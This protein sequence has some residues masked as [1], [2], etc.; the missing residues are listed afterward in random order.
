M[1]VNRL[2]RSWQP[3]DGYDPL[4]LGWDLYCEAAMETAYSDGNNVTSIHD[5]SGN[6][7]DVAYQA[8]THGTWEEN[9]K[10]GQ[11][12]FSF[13]DNEA[14]YYTDHS[15]DVSQPYHLFI[16]LNADTD[17]A[18]RWAID[19]FTVGKQCAVWAFDPATWRLRAG[20]PM[21]TEGI[22]DGWHIFEFL[23]N[24]ASSSW[25]LDGASIWSGDAG[26]W[27]FS[28]VR[29]ACSASAATLGYQSFISLWGVHPGALTGD[30]LT[31]YRN[32]LSARYDIAV[33]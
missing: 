16:V 33:A 25:L 26:A 29:L 7:R 4:A 1:L 8:G 2:P 24:G 3:S 27:D 17:P 9:I 13:T 18:N 20:A 6:S 11:A 28:L 15:K 32:Y 12:A 30:D 23:I 5:F 14:E 22:A 10:N 31:T 19:G 21:I